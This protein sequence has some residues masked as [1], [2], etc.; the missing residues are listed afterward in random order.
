MTIFIL[1][2]QFVLMGGADAFLVPGERDFFYDQAPD[3]M[4]SLET[5][6]SLTAYG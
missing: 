6:Y 5:S 1:L 2:P 3:S 4:K